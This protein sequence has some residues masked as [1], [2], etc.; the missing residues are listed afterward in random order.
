M[1]IIIAVL[2]FLNLIGAV[3]GS[4][5]YAKQKLHLAYIIQIANGVLILM[6]NS[7]LISKNPSENW[8]LVSPIV[9]GLW[10]ILM[11]F[12]GFENLKKEAKEC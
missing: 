5:L 10:L 11:A 2:G 7:L 1:G 12:V 9:L 3:Y 6:L 4:W 8:G